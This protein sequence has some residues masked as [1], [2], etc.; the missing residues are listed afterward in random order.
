MLKLW[1]QSVITHSVKTSLKFIGN[2]MVSL[3][4][5]L[6]QNICGG[7]TVVGFIWLESSKG[8]DIPFTH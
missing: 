3:H 6:D 2:Q 5:L 8:L 1:C 4:N 7:D